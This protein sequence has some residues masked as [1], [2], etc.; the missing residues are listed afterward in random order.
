MHPD[1]ADAENKF[2]SGKFEPVFPQKA[3]R[4]GPENRPIRLGKRC[5]FQ[6]LLQ[7]LPVLLLW[8]AWRD[9]VPI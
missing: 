7:W 5:F 4:T 6:R 2:Q 9:V 1:K 8:P 3:K